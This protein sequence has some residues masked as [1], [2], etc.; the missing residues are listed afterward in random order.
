[1]KCRYLDNP[2]PIGTVFSK[3]LINT[4][5]WKITGAPRLLTFCRDCYSYSVVRCTKNGKEFKETNS[6]DVNAVH[7]ET[8]VFK[9]IGVFP[10]ETKANI[11]H[12]NKVGAMKRRIN[13]LKNRI[14]RDTEEMKKLVLSITP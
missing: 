10:V 5:Y 8:D 7:E 3:T 11:E 4:I 12:G 13:Y 14:L 9:I 1:M 6:F 2:L